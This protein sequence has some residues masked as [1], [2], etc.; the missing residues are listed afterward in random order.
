MSV[1]KKIRRKSMNIFRW[2]AVSFLLYSKIPMPHFKWR[3]DDMRHSLVFFPIVG[4]VIGAA[5]YF[6][7][8]IP[9]VSDLPLFVR[10]IITLLIP[11][12]ITG[13]FHLDGYMDTTDALKSYR[14][15]EEK[16]RILK[17]PHIGAFAVIGLAAALLIMCASMGVI[18]EYGDGRKLILLAMIYPVSRALSGILAISLKKA[19][20]EGMLA[21]ETDRAGVWTVIALTVQLAAFA[22]FMVC[23][24]ITAGAAAIIG[25]LLFVIFYIGMTKK[26]FGGVTGDTAGYFVTV[27]ELV[28]CVILAVMSYISFI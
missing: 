5:T 13:G 15:T 9:A 7:N 1:Q 26:Q 14:P 22:A 18:L 2:L 25:I 8:M 10:S 12:I 3:D 28:S 21:D 11:I 4:A 20:N 6:I 27:S 16:L 24:D 19:K 23:L 17:D